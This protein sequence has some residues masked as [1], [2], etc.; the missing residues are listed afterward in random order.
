MAWGRKNI[1]L[2]K[3]GSFI[4]CVV[5]T[6]LWVLLYFSSDFLLEDYD[7]FTFLLHYYIVRQKSRA[8]V[9]FLFAKFPN[10]APT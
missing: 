4:K 2:W 10:F 1:M 3:I 5:Y 9:R 7:Y 8:V 6:L